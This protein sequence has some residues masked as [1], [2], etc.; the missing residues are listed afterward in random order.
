LDDYTFMS[1]P[2]NAKQSARSTFAARRRPAFHATPRALLD[3]GP[4]RL[5]RPV[6]ER[7]LP[8]LRDK[9]RAVAILVA[10]HWWLALP[11]RKS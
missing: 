9:A 4:A 8:A 10:R 7:G 3:S 6:A 1:D 2:D 5:V 11:A